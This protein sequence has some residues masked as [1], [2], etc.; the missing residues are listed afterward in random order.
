MSTSV[1]KVLSKE[2]LLKKFWLKG[3][4]YHSHSEAFISKYKIAVSWINDPKRSSWCIK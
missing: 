3:K 1:Q 2:Q 4:S